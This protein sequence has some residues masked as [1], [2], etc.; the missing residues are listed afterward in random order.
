[1]YVYVK[2]RSIYSISQKVCIGQK[3]VLKFTWDLRAYK[4]AAYFSSFSDFFGLFKP[5][6]AG[7][8]YTGHI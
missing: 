6:T 8:S 3:Y 4:Q 7:Y 1:M 2:E 5:H